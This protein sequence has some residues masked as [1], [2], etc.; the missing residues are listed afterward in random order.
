MSMVSK[1]REMLGTKQRIVR[2]SNQPTSILGP[3]FDYGRADYDYWARAREAKAD[4][5]ELAGLLLRPLES[6]IAS[7]VLGKLPT[8]MIE[9]KSA[10]EFITKW[11]DQ[12][13]QT[14]LTGFQDSLGLGDSYLLVNP[15]LSLVVLAPD[16]VK[17]IVD[18][19]DY[20]KIIGWTVTQVIPHPSQPTKK[21]TIVNEYTKTKRKRKILVD[22]VLIFNKSYN[23]FIN[24]IPVIHIP[25]NPRA[26]ERF[27]HPEAENLINLLLRYNEVLLAAVEGN[28]RQGRPTPV[29]SKLG[30]P[31]EVD[32]FWTQYGRTRTIPQPDGSTET[33]NYIEFDSDKVVTLGGEANFD[34][35]AP[36]QFTGDTRN[37]LSLFFYLYL[38]HSELPEFILGNAVESGD[39]PTAQIEPLVKFIE[40]RQAAAEPWFEELCYVAMAFN[41]LSDTSAQ[42]SEDDEISIFWGNLTRQDGQITL[43]TVQWAYMQGLLDRKTAL[44][45]MPLEVADPEQTLDDAEADYPNRPVQGYPSANGSTG[46]PDP[47]KLP[48]D[49][50]SERSRR[51]SGVGRDGKPRNRRSDS[52]SPS[53][54]ANDNG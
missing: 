50:G 9:K 32:A 52:R 48:T 25:N 51:R 2:Y 24:R 47:Q 10:K 44:A 19:N 11:L 17:P 18:D 39:D 21:M 6:K 36:G 42:V 26:Y 22:S 1:I 33:E 41:G 16:A 14:I 30:T 3:T 20:S 54:Q 13:K 7:W 5:I 37:L 12:N 35:K 8:V 34:W 45:L 40:K 46:G 49:N 53:P 43:Q 4:G 15:D 27:G 29:I 23:T 31:Q 28:I 38:Q